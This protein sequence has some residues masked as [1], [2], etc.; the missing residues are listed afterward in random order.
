LPGKVSFQGQAQYNYE[1]SRY[2]SYQQSTTLP[3]CRLSPTCAKD[4]SKAIVILRASHCQFAVKS[5]G[6]AAFA[7][8]SNIQGG[9]AIDM[10]N[11]NQLD[12]SKDQKTTSIGPGNRWVNVYSK[13]QTMGLS[14][15]GGRV[16]DIGVGGLT[17]GG[18]LFVSDK[19][20]RILTIL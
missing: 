17:L 11:L 12:V 16:S 7:G 9:V 6:H 15:V 20:S 14:V 4:V 19:E 18:M 10:V 8:S 3:A 5:G 13:L 2:W 1:E